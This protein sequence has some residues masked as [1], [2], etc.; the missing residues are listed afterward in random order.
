[1]KPAG[2]FLKFKFIATFWVSLHLACYA[3][4]PISAEQIYKD[5]S[6][7]DTLRLKASHTILETLFNKPDSVIIFGEQE[8]KLARKCGQKKYEAAA[9]ASVGTAFIHK[10]LYPKALQYFLLA[11]KLN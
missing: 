6:L 5:S 3:Q 2:I 11:L 8:L 7:N 1:M 10:G 4:N 9:L